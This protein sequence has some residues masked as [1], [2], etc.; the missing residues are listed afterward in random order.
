M[1][2]I[3]TPAKRSEMMAGIKG[4]DTKPEILLRK[5]LHGGGYRFRLHRKDLPG[6]PDLVLTKHRLVVFVNGCYWHGHED[7]SRFRLPKSNTAFWE[8]KIAGNR[9]RDRRDRAAL[10]AMGW[11]V[12]VVWEC[13]LSG[14]GRLQPD[15]LLEQIAG[16]LQSGS[17]AS[18]SPEREIRGR[19]VHAAGFGSC[20]SGSP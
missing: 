8:A 12:L 6:R 9:S 14:K 7:C 15:E 1:A 10:A 18:K 3:V 11:R 16:F 13:A 2:D 4:K 19:N 17:E 20:S 5:I